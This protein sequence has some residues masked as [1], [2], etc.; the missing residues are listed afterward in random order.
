[1]SEETLEHLNQQTLVGFT[2]KRGP[3]WHFSREHQGDESNH[4][5]GPIPVEAV[6]R[7]LFHWT[8]AEAPLV[9][10]YGDGEE[11]TDPT[12]KVIVRPDTKTVLGVFSENYQVHGYEEWLIDNVSH[13]VDTSFGELQIGSAGLL[14]G[15]RVGWVQLD[16]EETQGVND[17]KF[18]PFLS[19]ISSCD[20][21]MAS[22]Y[23]T[24]SQLIVCDNTM[25]VAVTEKDA[26]KVRV[27]HSKNSHQRI[28]GVRDELQL[29]WDTVDVFTAEVMDLTAKTVTDAQ[30]GRFL[31]EWTGLNNQDGMS[32]NA[33]TRAEGV[34]EELDGLW[35]DS[36]MVNPWKGTEW[37]VTAATNTHRHHFANVRDTSGGGMSKE[38]LRLERN[39]ERMVLG[40][41]ELGGLHGKTLATLA[42]V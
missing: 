13:I 7:R 32:K 38:R 24:G 40:G 12:R 25:A 6:R 35:H 2:D 20:G 28:A 27:K 33:V 41:K 18:R 15:G 31:D 30:W 17:V 10:R 5:T 9:V 34:R 1:M 14:R 36:D 11:I 23:M 16:L 42:R 22:T 19:A 8:P 26:T 29:M 37:G 39:T 21:S 4:Y 3:A